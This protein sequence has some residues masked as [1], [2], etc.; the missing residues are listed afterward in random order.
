MSIVY[1]DDKHYSD[2]ADAIR[3]KGVSGTF[4]PD[5]MAQAVLDIPSGGITPTGNINITDT[6]VTDVTNYAT[7]QVIDANLVA[8]NIKKNV[9]ILGVLGEFEGG[10]GGL[11]NVRKFTV[12]TNA[13]LGANGGII[14][15]VVTSGRAIY[16]LKANAGTIY[17]PYYCGILS[18]DY[19]LG[20]K[21]HHVAVRYDNTTNVAD[22]SPTITNG[23]VKIVGGATWQMQESYTVDVYEIIL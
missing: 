12:N 4:K 3:S 6:N 10:G 20:T 11:P 15:P 19:S 13:T 8:E 5:E 14:V 16:A 2:I 18:V 1:T 7:A 9:S 23:E 21:A 17:R 22:S